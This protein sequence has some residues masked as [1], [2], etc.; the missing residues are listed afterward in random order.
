MP[1]TRRWTSTLTRAALYVAVAAAWVMLAPRS[2]GGQMSY[3]IVA[4]A[5]MEPTLH[6]GDLVLARRATSYEV[7]QIV[8]YH[9]P[10]VGPVIHRIIDRQGTHYTL[11]GD[12]NSW[13]DSY[14]PTGD[15]IVGQSWLV[16]RRAGTLLMTLRTPS[17]LAVLSLLF[18]AVLVLTVGRGSR[19]KKAEGTADPAPAAGDPRPGR[20]PDGLIFTLAILAVGSLMLAAAAFTQPTTETVPGEA[21]FQ[22]TGRFSY[23]SGAPASVYSGSSLETGDPVYDA[24]VPSFV[25]DFDYQFAS[26]D[27]AE[28]EGTVALT[29]E[30]SEPNGWS[31]SLPLQPVTPFVGSLTH[32][33]GIVDMVTIRRM[34]SLL[35]G[36]TSLDRDAYRVDVIAEVELDGQLGGHAYQAT[37]EPSLL[38]ALDDF[39][40]YLRRG[41]LPEGGESD[42]TTTVQDGSLAFPSIEPA[43]LS[44]LGAQLPVTTARAVSVFGL[45]LA[46][47]AGAAVIGPTLVARRRGEAARVLA[48]YEGMLV[49]ISQPPTAAGEVIEV[50]SFADLARLSERTGRMILHA[51]A[52]PEHHFYLQDGGETYHIRLIDPESTA[53]AEG[54]A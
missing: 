11:Q 37:F 1:T 34:I 24:L 5:S 30:V 31:R 48:E 16:V 51:V 54:Q 52:G 32:A 29:L 21:P 49:S 14:T 47:G 35:E 2:F 40:L 8:T 10:Q 20:P 38:F 15:E 4:G 28:V 17:G 39:Q 7:D 22:H 12:N 42:P 23:H 6:Q 41:E 50:R 43:T 9:H 27:P 45:L 25:V 3:V 18:G 13:I 19:E 33:Q 53:G 36:A 46:L 26:A 44:I